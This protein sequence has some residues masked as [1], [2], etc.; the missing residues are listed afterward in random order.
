MGGFFLPEIRTPNSYEVTSMRFLTAGES[1]GSGL[2]G[3]LEGLPS[4]I[5]VDVK[6]INHALQQRQKGFG[7]GPRMS[8]EQDSVQILAGAVNGKTY[9][10]PLCMMIR[11]ADDRD[12][13]NKAGEPQTIPRPG[14]VDLAGSI[15]YGLK[16]LK[17][18]AERASGRTTAI[19]V[20]MGALAGDTL[21]SFGIE[22]LGLVESLEKIDAA[23]GEDS[24]EKLRG[25]VE[26]SPLRCPDQD[27]EKKMIEKITEY[28]EK[29]DTLGGII[30]LLAD[31]MPVGLGSFSHWDRRFDGRMAQA[32]MSIPGIK[33][34]EMGG[35]F[36][37]ARSSGSQANDEIH[38]DGSYR[39]RSNQAGGIE[40]GVTNGGRIVA[41]A[42]MKPIPTVKKG[43]QS[44][45]MATKKETLTQYVRSD[46]C[47]VPAASV[48]AEAM[49]SLVILDLFMEKFGADTM[50]EIRRNHDT[51]RKAA[52][53][54]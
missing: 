54:F 39:R 30:L 47:A 24:L 11:N 6:K 41:R 19:H 3:I 49:A 8:L 53:Q 17:T 12:L 15:K 7:R 46:V 48:V 18:P 34:V 29:G 27:A 28:E 36:S 42:A 37:L 33:G 22:V 43:I 13:F 20:A 35:G 31:G 16:D 45:D 25:S 2:V 9:G 23:I 5:A 21:A 10:A 51:Y 32:L 52:A 50:E 38:W 44:V 40:G 14:H 1:H 4:G 26:S